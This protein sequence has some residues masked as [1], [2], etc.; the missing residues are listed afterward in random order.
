MKRTLKSPR[1]SWVSGLGALVLA[2]MLVSGQALA[3]WPKNFGGALDDEASAITTT[4]TGDIYVTGSFTGT[5]DIGPITLSAQGGTDVFVAKL[6]PDGAVI[7]ARRFGGANFE[8]PTAIASDNAENA[9]VTGHFFGTTTLG[10]S[11]FDAP[12]GNA[13]V[14]VL[15]LNESDGRLDWAYQAGGGFDDF[16]TGIGIV[17][18]NPLNTPPT[19]DSVF[20]AGEYRGASTDFGPLDQLPFDTN[21]LVT[22][23]QPTGAGVGVF[24]ARIN[25]DN[26]RTKW[27][28]SR[29]SGAT[30]FEGITAMTVAEDGRIFITGYSKT[31]ETSNY[32]MTF[33]D[34]TQYSDPGAEIHAG[35]TESPPRWNA[36]DCRIRDRFPIGW[37]GDRGAC[38]GGA[39]DH[40]T[41]GGQYVPVP[42][43]VGNNNDFAAFLSGGANRNLMSETIDTSGLTSVTV[44]VDIIEGQDF[45]S[46]DTDYREDFRVLYCPDG[47]T[48]TYNNDAGWKQLQR[49][50]GGGGRTNGT[51]TYDLPSDALHADFKLRFHRVTGSGPC[52]DFWHVDNVEILSSTRDPF[53]AQV[54]NAMSDDVN[55]VDFTG[56]VLDDGVAPPTAVP[57]FKQ[58][59]GEL[60]PTGLAFYADPT[61]SE[62]ALYLTTT[63]AGGG[64]VSIDNAAANLTV[65]GTA[66]FKMDLEG[67]GLKGEVAK[68]IAG[69]NL[70]G[71][72]TD[73]DGNV[74]VVVVSKSPTT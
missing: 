5:I 41:P 54:I 33:D 73:L 46:E 61:G 62:E 22:L 8:E 59:P 15:K 47:A 2:G 72:T 7:W 63:H 65:P 51:F 17:P 56:D 25:A 28:K 68:A 55:D 58:I 64:S 9:Y 12:N 69:A 27:A 14:F 70:R 57:G 10:G 71:T 43:G 3:A 40:R 42:I 1:L 16:A 19:P 74:Y 35:C 39:W 34:P 13:D 29:I 23:P 4:A 20:I 48:C 24:I 30:G 11:T 49:F 67:P 32:L 18:G 44:K 21:D 26:G 37:Q 52:W 45:F 50:S 53:I 38:L 31:G 66:I 6:R 36:E 60:S